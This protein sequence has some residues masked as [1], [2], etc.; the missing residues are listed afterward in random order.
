MP[1][2]LA[3]FLSGG[4]P[5]TRICAWCQT[6]MPSMGEDAGV[7]THGICM[8]CV[9]TLVSDLPV[10]LE[11]YLNNL[12]VPVVAMD[13]DGVATLANLKAKKLLSKSSEQIV[14]WRGGDVFDCVHAQS[15]EGCSR[16]IHCSGCVVR[17]CIERTH[18][19]GE[20]Q[21]MIP[22][23]LKHGDPDSP[24][25]IA[26]TITTVKRGE[27]VLLMIHQVH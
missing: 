3:V 26:L 1:G 12:T 5:L 14:N 4:D 24:S 25:A 23:T 22:A 9:H 16:T 8:S 7:V 27:V 11:H 6:V 2:N 13:G 21:V 17:N 19:T 20:P 15:P 10:S 18:R